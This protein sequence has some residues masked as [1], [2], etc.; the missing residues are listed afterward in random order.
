M[1]ERKMSSR[2][3]KKTEGMC[4]RIEAMINGAGLSCGVTAA[5][6]LPPDE[7]NTLNY[8]LFNR[9]IRSKCKVAG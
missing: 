9:E 5:H 2:R 4:R 3:D 1:T 8:R 7:V 6:Q